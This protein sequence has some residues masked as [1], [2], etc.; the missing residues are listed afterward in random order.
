MHINIKVTRNNNIDLYADGKCSRLEDALCNNNIAKALQLLRIGSD[1]NYRDK[2]NR[3]PLMAAAEGSTPEMCQ[4]L[5]DHGADLE[6]KDENGETAY[7]YACKHN[8]DPKVLEVFENAG[9]NIYAR[10]EEYNDTALFLAV[11]Y[12]KNPKVIRHLI[13]KGF[14]VDNNDDMYRYTPLMATAHFTKNLDILRLVLQATEEIDL[15]DKNG[16]TA[17]MH[18]AYHNDDDPKIFRSMYSY[19]KTLA[20]EKIKDRLF[21]RDNDGRTM[22]EIA[23]SEGNTRVAEAIQEV[24]ERAMIM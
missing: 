14:D 5:I 15:V 16:C 10:N 3:T 22:F 4:F 7:L 19:L 23:V 21:Q 8:K 13:H 18:T 24:M 2:K 1:I 11:E 20:P 9:C 12:N 6:L 17:F